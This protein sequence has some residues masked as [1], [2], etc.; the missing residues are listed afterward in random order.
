MASL[1]EGRAVR[2]VEAHLS[3]LLSAWVSHH[4][5]TE[6]TEDARRQSVVVFRFGRVA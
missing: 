2:V 3:A 4:G 5:G 1:V 6:S